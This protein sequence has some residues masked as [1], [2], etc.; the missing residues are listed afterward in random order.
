MEDQSLFGHHI[1]FHTVI[2][3]TFDREHAGIPLAQE[4]VAF[5]LAVLPEEYHGSGGHGAAGVISLPG[6][7]SAGFG[8]PGPV[9][10]FFP[11][12]RTDRL[13][14]LYGYCGLRFRYRFRCRGLFRGHVLPV[15]CRGFRFRGLLQSG[16]DPGNQ[17]SQF[18]R[19]HQYVCKGI[20]DQ[21]GGS[22][23]LMGQPDAAE[24]GQTHARGGFIIV[25]R[26]LRFLGEHREVEVPVRSLQDIR[27]NHAFRVTADGYDY[28]RIAQAGKEGI[29]ILL[30]IILQIGLFQIQKYR[31]VFQHS[32][33]NGVGL[34]R[35]SGGRRGTS[36][37]VLTGYQLQG[38]LGLGRGN[39]GFGS[40]LTDVADFII[41]YREQD[42]H[43]IL[44]HGMQEVYNGLDSHMPGFLHRIA[45]IAGG[46]QRETDRM[47]AHLHGQPH[48]FLI[49]GIQESG[50][51]MVAP[52]PDRTDRMD[53]IVRFQPV[54][55]CHDSGTGI[56]VA[57]LLT[58]IPQEQPACFC[59][60][61]AA[62]TSA[63]HQGLIGLI[64][65][66]LDRQICNP[67]F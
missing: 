30:R 10:L 40:D 59:I 50:F 38:T 53:D 44:R 41:K 39:I 47:A 12:G 25:L 55:G 32:G 19:Q 2:F 34:L 62:D 3:H 48:G 57:D 29:E 21:S 4:I 42:S 67:A 63:F 56:A 6:F 22:L 28:L 1:L 13:F 52:S 36:V 5:V 15:I 9:R 17:I 58:G 46:Q 27:G 11:G 60:N 23:G 31:T 16:R 20:Q 8:C 51:T 26:D 33:I 24:H 65:Q 35:R 54:A 43:V 49:S 61:F 66:S 45:E 37:L 64:D 7:L 14:R 18:E